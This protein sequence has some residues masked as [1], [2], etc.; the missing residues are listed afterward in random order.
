VTSVAEARIQIDTNRVIGEVHPHLF[1]NFA[2]HLGRC[3]YGGIFE[4]GSPLSDS[5]GYR[6]DVLEAVK[7]FGISILRWPGGNFA[8]GYNWMDGVGLRDHEFGSEKVRPATRTAA[9]TMADHGFTYVFPRHSLAILRL[10][11]P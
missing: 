1:G 7:P 10:R 8:S 6:K 5:E 4:D 9:L 11:I 3:I 2:E